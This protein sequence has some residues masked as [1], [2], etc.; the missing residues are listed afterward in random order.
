MA[1]RTLARKVLETEA[2][3]ILAL[4]SRLDQRFDR[5]RV[6]HAAW[7]TEEVE[8]QPDLDRSRDPAREL[9]GEARSCVAASRVD[10][11]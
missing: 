3:A 2:A 10:P 6:E 5:D 1:D 7:M 8:C 4:V 9:P 11:G